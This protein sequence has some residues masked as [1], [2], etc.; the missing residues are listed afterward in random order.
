M[1]ISTSM[2]NDSALNG[3]LQDESA[4]ST[5]Q[6]QLSTGLEHQYAGRQSGGRGAAAAAQ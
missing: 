5:T 4:L 6:N 2:L 3:I 1:R